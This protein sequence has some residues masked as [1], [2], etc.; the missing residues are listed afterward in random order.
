MGPNHLTFPITEQGYYYYP[1]GTGTYGAGPSTTAAPGSY[2]TAAAAAG[3]QPTHS[4]FVY[5]P[6]SADAHAYGTMHFRMRE[7]KTKSRIA[8]RAWTLVSRY[9][10]VAGNEW[11]VM[12]T[13]EREPCPVVV[14]HLC[15]VI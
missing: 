9:P 15:S 5:S 10:G 4:F 6:H 1:Q 13:L 8:K 2:Q 14:R 12:T 7:K 11:A 3:S